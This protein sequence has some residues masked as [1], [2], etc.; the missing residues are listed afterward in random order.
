MPLLSSCL[1]LALVLYNNSNATVNDSTQLLRVVVYSGK[2]MGE[3]SETD[4]A[5]YHPMIKDMPATER[6]RERLRDYGPG[7]LR[8]AELLAIILR[9]GTKGQNVLSLADSL[10]ARYGGL[11]G[12]AERNLT[13]LQSEKGLVWPRPVT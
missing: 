4:R 3:M 8:T 10:V 1:L 13:E 9:T 11:S 2:E 12:L 6:P 7:A 5:V